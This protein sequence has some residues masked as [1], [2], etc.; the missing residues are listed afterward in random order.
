MNIELEQVKL[1]NFL[2]FGSK[3]QTVPFLRGLNVIIGEDLDTGR[4]NGAGKSS[5]MESIPFGLFGQV[6]RNIKKEQ[7]INWKNRKACEVQLDFIKNKNKYRVVRGI[8]PDVFEIYKNSILINKPSHVKEYQKILN[9]ILGLNYTTFMSL[10]HSNINSSVK[11]LSMKKPEKRKFL[12]KMFGLSLYTKLNENSN[13]K[14]KNINEKIREI[15]ISN[16]YKEKSIIESEQ[17]IESLKK[18]LKGISLS[19]TLLNDAQE[20]LEELES[21]IPEI[22]RNKLDKKISNSLFLISEYEALNVKINNKRFTVKTWRKNTDILIQEYEDNKFKLKE[23][24]KLIKKL[25]GLIKKDGDIKYLTNLISNM[26]SK[27]AKHEK[28]IEKQT[29]MISKIKAN[30]SIVR[31][32][33][34]NK[35]KQIHLLKDDKCPTCGGDLTD[36]KLLIKFKEELN[37]KCKHEKKLLSV[38]DEEDKKRDNFYT[39]RSSI[40]KK[41]R[42]TEY[43][44]NLIYNTKDKIIDVVGSDTDI[45]KLNKDKSRYTK[46]LHKL[47]CLLNDSEEKNAKENRKFHLL[48][49]ENDNIQKHVNKVIDQEIEVKRIEEKIKNE[50]KLQVNLKSLLEKDNQNIKLLEKEIK[51]SSIKVMKYNEM[52]DY[53]NYI[54]FVCKDENIKQYAISSIMPFLNKYTNKYLSKVG[55]G[56][57]VTLDKW[58]DAIINGPGITKAS[59]GSLSGGEG[60]GIDI[61][62]Q[63][64]FLDIDRLQAG[65]FFDLIVFDELL[66]SSI[67]DKGIQELFDIVKNKQKEDN[68]KVFIISHRSELKDYDEIDREYYVTKKDGYSEVIIK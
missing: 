10:I 35:Q 45:K 8:K 50:K 2:S 5:L 21:R 28:S 6:H 46:T 4:S 12:E 64:A 36:G 43:K 25:N 44:V 32:E 18:Q 55:Y 34:S 19:Q 53:L 62:I 42:E 9:D 3:W 17:R 20:K 48:E 38:F 58:L 23:R 27:L 56:F 51:S 15:E 14:L 40:S 65:V 60:R 47:D 68:S 33:I 26:R 66:D 30:I 16:N 54:K 41:I 37:N 49:E 61:A 11:I 52:K 24:N 13:V 7:I 31:N 59:Y 67:D 39:L 63:L 29:N 57:Y 22:D 1:K